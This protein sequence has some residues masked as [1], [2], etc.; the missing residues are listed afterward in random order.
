MML[1]GLGEPEAVRIAVNSPGVNK[2]LG[3]LK[4]R[5][6]TGATVL[7]ITRKDSI[8]PDA[9]TTE[10]RV[11]NGHEML[12]VGDVL[13]VAGSREAINAARALLVPL[14]PVWDRRAEPVPKEAGSLAGQSDESKEN[15]AAPVSDH[16][17]V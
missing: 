5:G 10:L 9:V 17:A 12:R 7:A 2:T 14:N 13:A 6:L 11:P 8:A 4:I 16:E 3:E 15:A 1:P